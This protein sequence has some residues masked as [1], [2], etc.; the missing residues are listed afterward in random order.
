MMPI[1]LGQRLLSLAAFEIFIRP[2]GSDSIPNL[3]AWRP[4]ESYVISTHKA[5]HAFGTHRNNY[6]DH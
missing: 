6:D 1:L 4:S 3:L 2:A 5:A